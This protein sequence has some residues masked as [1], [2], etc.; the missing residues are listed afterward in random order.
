MILIFLNRFASVAE[1]E[2]TC[3]AKL[4]SKFSAKNA[5]CEKPAVEGPRRC[6][7]REFDQIIHLATDIL[8]CV[9]TS[10]HFVRFTFNS[11]LGKCEEMVYGGCGGGENLFL[12]MTD[13]VSACMQEEEESPAPVPRSSLDST[14]DSEED[15]EEDIC[16]LPPVLPGPMGCLAFIPKWSYSRSEGGCVQLIYGGCRGTE[17][18]FDSEEQCEERCGQHSDR[19]S[20]AEVCSLPLVPGPCKQFQTSFGFNSVTGRCEAFGYGGKYLDGKTGA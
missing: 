13:C 15:S 10:G 7:G 2:T 14:E 16:S 4:T 11:A 5:L 18:L 20:S 19:A 9:H 6:L 8:S 12:S 1:C 3:S 17:N